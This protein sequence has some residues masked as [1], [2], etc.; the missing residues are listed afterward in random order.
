MRK[1]VHLG[2]VILSPHAPLHKSQVQHVKHVRFIQVSQV[3]I[4]LF[5]TLLRNVSILCPPKYEKFALIDE[6]AAVRYLL[7]RV[8]A[9]NHLL[10]LGIPDIV[11]DRL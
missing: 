5:E 3:T 2:Y 10:P 7:G 1:I 6:A 4:R 8:A 9:R 11:A